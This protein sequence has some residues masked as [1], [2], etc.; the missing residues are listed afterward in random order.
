[1]KL[2]GAVDEAYLENDSRIGVRVNGNVYEAFP[3]TVTVEDESRDGGF[4]LYLA[5]DAWKDGGEEI[6]ILI[7]KGDTWY[8]IGG[9][10]M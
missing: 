2:S 7:Q 10:V 5:S 6:D 4:V 1:M 3:A 8:E 9:C